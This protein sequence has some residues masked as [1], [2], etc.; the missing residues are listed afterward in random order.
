MTCCDG[1]PPFFAS[2]CIRCHTWTNHHRNE[3]EESLTEIIEIKYGGKSYLSKEE[4]IQAR[5]IGAPEPSGGA[6]EMGIT[7]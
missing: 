6:C 7:S 3:A 5:G 1:T 4:M 2:L